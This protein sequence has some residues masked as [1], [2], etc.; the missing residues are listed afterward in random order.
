MSSKVIIVF[1]IVISLI[2][3]YWLLNKKDGSTQPKQE[4]PKEL[5]ARDKIILGFIEK[6]PDVNKEVSGDIDYTFQFEDQIIKPGKPIIFTGILEDIF[7]KES[8][9]YIRFSPSYW[10][11][12]FDRPEEYYTVSGCDEKIDEI[13]NKKGDSYS[14]YV[15]VATI[16]SIRKPELKIDGSVDGEDVEFEYSTS[17]I[18][19]ITGQ[20]IDL[21]FVENNE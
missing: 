2:G 20:C 3:G 8:R 10:D 11:Y 16:D 19:L 12:S 5:N 6:Y 18:F 9:L 17:D 7:R 15:V 13:I 4:E 21:A 1:I 14:E